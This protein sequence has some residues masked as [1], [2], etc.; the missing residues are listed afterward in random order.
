[1]KR[2]WHLIGILT[3]ILGLAACQ[4]SYYIEHELHGIWQVTS[5]TNKST[6]ETS[7]PQ[8]QLYY[9]FQRSMVKLGYKHLNIPEAMEYYLSNF[10]FITSDSIG[11]G[12]FVFGSIKEEEK[13]PVEN[14][15]KFG[16]YQDYTIFGVKHNKDELELSSEK[17]LIVLRKY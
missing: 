11:M 6:G 13:V 3:V 2:T 5:I 8:G 16:I 14:L 1:M 17:S 7:N 12:G 9:L 10:E 15:H 4:K